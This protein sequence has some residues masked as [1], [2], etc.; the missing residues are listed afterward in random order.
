[1]TPP[2]QPLDFQTTRRVEFRDTDAA[3]IMHFSAFF[4]FME[5]V[6]HEFLRSIGLSVILDEPQDASQ[7]GHERQFIT[8]PRVHCECDYFSPIRFEQIVDL[9]LRIVRLGD[10]SVTYRV[11]FSRAGQK[12]ASGKVT[13]V[14]CRIRG[15]Q[16]PHSIRIPDD[17]RSRMAPYVD[18]DAA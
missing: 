6:E 5:E 10:K 1:M 7:S 11:D 3:G 18:P 4:L 13:A 8:W 16:A 17:I 9:R 15:A 2:A 14:C 12:I